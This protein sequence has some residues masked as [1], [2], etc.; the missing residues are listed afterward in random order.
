MKKRS[1]G[2]GLTILL[3]FGLFW[4]ALVGTFDGLLGC[5]FYR[6]VRASHFAQ[7]TGQV[8]ASEVTHHRGSKGGTTYGVSIH[9]NY[10][11]DGQKFSGDRYRYANWSSSDSQWAHD[12][13]A[14]NP[15]G[16]AVPVFYNPKNPQ[17]SLLSPGVTGG[18]CFMLL[19]L[20]PFNVVMLGIWSLPCAA[21]R[22]KWRPSD[23]GGVKWTTDGRRLRVRLPRYSPWVIGLATIGLTSFLATFVVALS[24]GFH[25]RFAVV[26]GTWGLIL[27]LGAGVALWTWRRQ[28]S[29]QSDLVIDEIEGTVQLPATF[30]RKF[31]QTVPLAALGEVEVETIANRGSRGGT[32]Y[33]YAVTLPCDGGSQKLTEWYDEQR[34]RDFAGWLRQ[35]LKP[36]EPAAPPRKT[37]WPD[38]LPVT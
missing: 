24:G 25:P 17:D 27:V 8:T 18:D 35:R 16:A 20:T 11:V 34:A 30:S 22:R 29:G 21:L 13:V 33:S 19:F 23:C 9:Y 7:T 15:V 32:T 38:T 12:A 14:Q 36:A 4:T 10:T 28:R 26:M 1:Q 31:P 6:Q 3:I 37:K 5:N 2:S